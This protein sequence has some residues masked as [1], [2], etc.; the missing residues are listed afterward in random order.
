MVSAL[1]AAGGVIG[2]VFAGFVLRRYLRNGRMSNLCWTVGL[3]LWGIVSMLEAFADPA[4]GGWDANGYR[5]YYVHSA[6]LVALLGAGT[7]F[8]LKEQRYGQCFLAFTILVALAFSIVAAVSPTDPAAL[9]R[10]GSIGGDGWAPADGRMAAPRYVTFLLTIPGSIVLI[11][12][13]FLSWWRTKTVYNVLIGV[14]AIVIAAA[15]VLARAGLE[16]YIPLGNLL[17]V[18]L[19][20]I[21]MVYAA[22][23]VRLRTGEA[24]AAR[25]RSVA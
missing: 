14:G 2:F 23:E 15:G 11:G 5:I 17:S 6:S 8:L 25:K 16:E 4:T 21:G 7:L 19:M 12:G 10:G 13:A 9:A 1:S 24:A 22:E 20:F 3:L 18:S